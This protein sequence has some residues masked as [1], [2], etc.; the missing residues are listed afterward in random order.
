MRTA[1]L[2]LLTVLLWLGLSWLSV[3]L[4]SGLTSVSRLASLR[5]RSPKA[6]HAPFR[7]R[8]PPLPSDPP[9]CA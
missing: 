2:W 4:A 6:A 7:R 5:P 8:L 1:D 9:D 3:Y